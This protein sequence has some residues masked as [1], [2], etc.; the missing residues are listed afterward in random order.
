MREISIHLNDISDSRELM[1][2]KPYPVITYFIYIILTLITI[3]LTWSYFSEIDIVSKGRGIVRPN[4]QVSVVKTSRAGHVQSTTLMEGRLVKE[5]EILYVI[6]H[7]DL[8]ASYELLTDEL[9]LIQ[10]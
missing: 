6:Q 7:D 3:A 2:S 1:E 9:R 5:G 10:K 8:Q 4:S